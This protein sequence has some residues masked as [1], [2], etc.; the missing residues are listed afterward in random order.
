MKKNRVFKFIIF[1]LI[2]LLFCSIVMNSVNAATNGFSKAK[3]T[4]KDSAF[5]SG[6]EDTNITKFANNSAK[7]AITIMRIVGMT[8]AVTMLLAVSIKYMVSSASDRADIKKHAVVYVVGAVVL[9]GA[10]GILGIINDLTMNSLGAN[11]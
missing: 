8:V 2:T 4:R 3:F 6:A 1:L 9:F 7:I 11:N 5:E 10:V